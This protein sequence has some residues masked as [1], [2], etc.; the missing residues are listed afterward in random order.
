MDRASIT[1]DSGRYARNFDRNHQPSLTDRAI[2]ESHERHAGRF[3]SRQARSLQ[4]YMLLRPIYFAV[5]DRPLYYP[6]SYPSC[7]FSLV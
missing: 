7:S 5:N 2:D 3:R 6:L 1:Q 4:A